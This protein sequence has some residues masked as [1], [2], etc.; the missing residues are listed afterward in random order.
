MSMS[1]HSASP[2]YLSA[3]KA[4]PQNDGEKSPGSRNPTVQDCEDQTL[5]ASQRLACILAALLL[6]KL[7]ASIR[8]G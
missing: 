3:A 2:F 1:L 6:T 7:T 8:L 5:S 4:L